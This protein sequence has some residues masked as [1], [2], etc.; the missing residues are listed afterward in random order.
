MPIKIIEETFFPI[1]KLLH[2]R[3][4]KFYPQAP[5]RGAE[6]SQS[7]DLKTTQISS[8]STT[9]NSLNTGKDSS[10]LWAENRPS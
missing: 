6:E 9:F 10:R 2:E 7:T 4:Q 8:R 3:N 5:E 1:G